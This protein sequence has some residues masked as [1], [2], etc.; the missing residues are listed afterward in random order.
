M[1]WYLTPL[2]ALYAAFGHL[3]SYGWYTLLRW[4]VTIHGLIV[5]IGYYSKSFGQNKV[6]DI[7]RNIMIVFLLIVIFMFC[8]IFSI[9]MPKNIWQCIDG[10]VAVV[11]WWS[12]FDFKDK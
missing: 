2:F 8:P 6:S 4:M 12:A 1:Y 11:Y 10:I 7:K 9:H 3:P 5:L